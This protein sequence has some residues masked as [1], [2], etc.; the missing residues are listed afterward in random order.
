MIS[1][2]WHITCPL[3]KSILVTALIHGKRQQAQRICRSIC[4]EKQNS[5]LSKIK[6][7]MV[8]KR[9]A[10]AP[11]HKSV[12]Q[13]GRHWIGKKGGAILREHKKRFWRDSIFSWY[14]RLRESFSV[15][16]IE[17]VSLRTDEQAQQINSKNVLPK[18][19]V[20]AIQNTFESVLPKH[21]LFCQNT[22]VFWS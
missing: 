16:S 15:C 9:L 20:L 14:R 19:S 11:V 5:T 21:F 2:W 17:I 3:C 13:T 10:A 4:R 22:F 1:E 18:Q 7:R 6:T 12:R 8:S